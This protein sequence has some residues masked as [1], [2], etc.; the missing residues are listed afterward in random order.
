[1]GSEYYPFDPIRY[2]WDDFNGM[3]IEDLTHKY[4]RAQE[5]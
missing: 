4:G 1:M 3:P 2:G 5:V